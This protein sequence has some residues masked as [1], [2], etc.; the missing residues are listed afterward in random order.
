MK[1]I[2]LCLLATAPTSPNI[3]KISQKCY[4]LRFLDAMVGMQLAG[5]H[6]GS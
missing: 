1:Q 6:P 5:K 3:L 2:W 4:V